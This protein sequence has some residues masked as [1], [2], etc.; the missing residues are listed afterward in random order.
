MSTS[1]PAFGSS[2]KPFGRPDPQRQQSGGQSGSGSGS[3]LNSSSIY[4]NGN[5]N[6]HENRPVNTPPNGNFSYKSGLQFN[7]SSNNNNN[8][9]GNSGGNSNSTPGFGGSGSGN[10]MFSQPSFQSQSK[11][12]TGLFGTSTSASASASLVTTPNFGITNGNSMNNITQS[13]FLSQHANLGIRQRNVNTDYNASTNANA[14][15]NAN[16]G[17]KSR[18]PPPKRSMMTM[19][20]E[21]IHPAPS[22]TTA[23]APTRNTDADNHIR[24][25]DIFHNKEN[26]NTNDT[27]H[28]LAIFKQHASNVTPSAGLSGKAQSQVSATTSTSA[29]AA[30]ESNDVTK[31]QLNYNQWVV[32]YGFT[33]AAQYATVMSN[34]ESYGTIISKYP[35]SPSKG[36]G[37]S[38][39]ANP[40]LS[41]NWVCIHYQSA[42][43]ADKALCQHGSLLD[44][45]AHSQSSSM[46]SSSMSMPMIVGVMKMDAAV[47]DKLGLKKF[48]IEGSSGVERI[49]VGWNLKQGVH[50]S[51]AGAG[52]GAGNPTSAW[53]EKDVLLMGNESRGRGSGPIRGGVEVDMVRRDSVCYKI[54]AWVFEW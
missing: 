27:I 19:T 6:E 5:R 16:A 15:A 30:T 35:S 10:S 23:S 28:S 18:A 32:L 33:N 26:L 44:V 13:S 53:D 49:G 1:L 17:L 3:A 50:G 48:L 40:D 47:A 34:F 45:H 2:N 46:S 43:Q 7:S 9:N 11:P 4:N 24:P 8:G 38:A 20:M 21:H 29:A 12:E 39:S 51:G 52:A 25:L 31:K 42:L 22:N 41:T 54:L 36:G 37:Q 14:N